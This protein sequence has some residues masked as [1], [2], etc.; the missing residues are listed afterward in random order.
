MFGVVPRELWQRTNPP[1]ERNRIEMA[2]RCLLVRGEGRNVLIDTGIGDKFAAREAEIY[3]I[4]HRQWTLAKALRERGLAPE[5]VTDVVLT[6][7]HFDHAGGA[8]ARDGG[9]LRPAFPNAR[10]HLQEENLKTAS[11]PNLRERRSYLQENFVPLEEAGCLNLHR[12]E[13]EI[14]PGIHLL[15]VSG[16][17]DGQHLVRIEGSD[18]AAAVF[19]GDLIPTSSHV[20]IPWVMGYDLRPLVSMREKEELLSEAVRN[21]WVLVFEHDPRVAAARVE[22]TEKGFSV[23]EAVAL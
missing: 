12:G 2:M 18:G 23:R 19:C 21:D 17:T 1:D 10:Y 22:R 13:E 7:L 14:L 9:R 5:D 15:P 6:H 20:P 11:R 4:D 3:K 16:H 8:T